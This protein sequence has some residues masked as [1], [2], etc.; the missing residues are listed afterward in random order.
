MQRATEHY[1]QEIGLSQKKRV[2]LFI[3]TLLLLL[4]R[5]SILGERFNSFVFVCFTIVSI[6]LLLIQP[7]KS[8]WSFS[9]NV[10]YLFFLIVILLIYLFFQ[11]LILTDIKRVV[12]NS[13]I[14]ILGTSICFLLVLKKEHLNFI[15]QSFINIIFFLSISAFVTYSIYLFLGLK[16]TRIPLV[17]NL[18]H[19]APSYN[20]EYNDFLGDHLLFFPFTGIWSALNVTNLSIPRHVGIFREPG[21]AQIFFL[22]AYFVTFFIETSR[23]KLKRLVI[24]IGAFLTLSTSGLLSFIGG[25]IA[26]RLFGQG[27]I[28]NGFRIVSTLFFFILMAIAFSN[29]PEIGFLSK[30]SSE[31]GQYRSESFENSAKLLAKHTMLGVGY[32]NGFETS[33]TGIVNSKQFVGLIGVGYQIGLVGIVLY[34][35]V[36]FAGLYKLGSLKTLCIYVPCL[37]TLV[38]SQPSYNDVFVF[39]LLLFDTRSLNIEKS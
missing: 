22:T 18:S 5:P 27:R 20:N 4:F 10:V 26:L 24:L 33:E 6:I 34:L 7:S 32:Y 12:V 36:W 23:A 38:F 17:A 19:L 35:L 11:G 39:F 15:L 2:L 9:R 28:P 37:V 13:V 21:M 29:L 14:V 3:W 30:I 25:Y 8:K 16:V 31:S 1:L